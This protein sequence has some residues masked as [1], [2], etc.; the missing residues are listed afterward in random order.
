M[1][2]QV[3]LDDRLVGTDKVGQILGLNLRFWAASTVGFTARAAGS[4][5]GWKVN[6]VQHV[7][8]N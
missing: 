1:D 6:S 2:S 8:S 4:S 7:R 3:G 5:N